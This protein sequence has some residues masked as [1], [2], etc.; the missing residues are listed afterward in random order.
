MNHEEDWGQPDNRNLRWAFAAVAAILA[1]TTG[2]GWVTLSAERRRT[3]ELA[4][5]NAALN[6]GLTRMQS[7]LDAMS[8]RLLALQS[9]LN[10][11]KTA[12]ARPPEPA[13]EAATTAAPVAAPVRRR[14]AGRVPPKPKPVKPA[15]P[16]APLKDPRVDELQSRVGAQQEAL[17]AAQ[18]RITRTRDELS[19]SI[20]RTNEEL[21]QLQR[22]GERQYFS[23]DLL[24][25]KQFQ[26]VGS[27]ALSLRKVDTKR[28]SYQ[29][30]L[31]VD[32]QEMEKKNI[33]LFEPVWISSEASRQPV[34]LVVNDISKDRIRGY[35]S[36]PRQ[37]SPAG[38]TGLTARTPGLQAR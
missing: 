24:K 22:R 18:E 5:R 7:R 13:P 17:S 16:Q 26:R 2:L 35:I 30:R 37:S 15:Q 36:E 23:F 1:V 12:A 32:D 10:E 11:V 33:L 21:Q 28:H 34:Q 38:Q 20:A 8:S 19:G 14:T 4:Q 3:E 25:S 9:S 31:R 27:L 29:I 6:E